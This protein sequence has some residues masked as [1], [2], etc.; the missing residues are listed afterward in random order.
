[1]PDSRLDARD[2]MASPP[3]SSWGRLLKLV[4][5][6]A[7]AAV[8]ALLP[9][10]VGLDSGARWALFILILAALLWI[11]EAMPPFAV[12][13]L[14]IG[15]EIAILGRPGGVFATKPD[16][17]QQF[18]VVWGS[19]LIW[20]F[21]G[22]FVLAAAAEKTGL[23]TWLAR[24]VLQRLGDRPAV[25]LAGCMGI[26]YVFS[27]F[28]SNTATA[29]MMIAV[30]TPIINAIHKGDPFRK[31]LLLGVAFAANLGGMGTIIGS[32]PNA[33]AAGMLRSVQ[34][35]DFAH[36]MIVGIPPSLVLLALTWMFLNRRYP[37]AATR[38]DLSPLNR[39]ERN[40]PLVAM[41]LRLTVMLTFAA[42]VLLWLTSGLHGI[43][44]TVV[45][46]LPITVFT[47]IGLLDASDIRAI[48]WDVLLLIAGG[49]SLGVAVT[50][51][52][53]A[54]WLV[55]QLPMSRFGML[56]LAVALT[57]FVV[58]LSNLMS[59]TAAANILIPIALTA[60]AGFE[61]LV[62]ISIGLGASAAMSL[63]IST[64]P[65]AIVYGT[66][67]LET[68]DLLYGGGAIGLLAPILICG[69]CWLV[70]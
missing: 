53:L 10:Y 11:S 48:P 41:W 7:T 37:A 67:E 14:A 49:L 25:Q 54:A 61:S 62:V 18:L 63:P 3:T 19:P 13:L 47:T 5:S 66:G 17:W 32:P 55:Q 30:M 43:P 33:I 51:T 1:M 45:S 39:S 38:L 34:P 60:S 46:F 23:S 56:G 4:V 68:R 22:G 31:A 52:G 29:T 20:L 12:G 28:V 40:G 59:N 64:P 44:A 65:N 27:M 58:L 8:V 70:L 35:V 42:T 24:N 15:L 26:T 50:E 69:W 21:F 57:Y 9:E 6:A 36:W 16:Q 2:E